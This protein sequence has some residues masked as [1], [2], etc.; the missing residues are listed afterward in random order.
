MS[1]VF[2]EL[3]E[4]KEGVIYGGWGMDTVGKTNTKEECAIK[5]RQEYPD[6]I[7]VIWDEF[8]GETRENA[9]FVPH[10]CYAEFGTRITPQTG[11]KGVFGCLFN[12]KCVWEA[13]KPNECPAKPT[14]LPYCTHD[15]KDGELCEADGC[16]WCLELSGQDKSVIHTDN[17]Q[18][19]DWDV[20]R[21]NKQ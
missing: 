4:F 14:K 21:C 19:G 12:A 1:M 10:M 8:H 15:M 11:V 7:G 13:I 2:T 6:A 17:C 9:E 5:V 16:K 3:C 20:F 18:P